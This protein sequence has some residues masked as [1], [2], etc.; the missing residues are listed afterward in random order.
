VRESGSASDNENDD[1]NNSSKN[2]S[3]GLRY[4]DYGD[5]LSPKLKTPSK[6][7]PKS[8]NQLSAYVNIKEMSHSSPNKS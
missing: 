4:T 1:K 3:T 8:Q 2:K 6:I 5:V 7:A